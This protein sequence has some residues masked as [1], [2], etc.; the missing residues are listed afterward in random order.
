MPKF[1]GPRIKLNSYQEILRVAAKLNVRYL[2]R[3]CDRKLVTKSGY[4]EEK[5]PIVPIEYS[6]RL[7]EIVYNLRSS[8]DQLI[9]QLVHANYKKPSHRNEFPMF[10]DESRFNK[11]EKT[12]LAGVSLRALARI[13]EL[14]P[15]R[16]K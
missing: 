6:I 16:K 12:K 2:P 13:K 15:F 14:Q 5:T 8:L 9:W 7:G 3:S 11:A 1:N 4:S 10:D